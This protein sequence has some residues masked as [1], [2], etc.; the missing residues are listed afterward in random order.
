MSRDANVG[1]QASRR[2]CPDAA[3]GTKVSGRNCR[4]T[5][6]DGCGVGSGEEYVPSYLMLGIGTK[7]LLQT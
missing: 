6:E 4:R 7:R 2:N 1:K 5:A 3:V